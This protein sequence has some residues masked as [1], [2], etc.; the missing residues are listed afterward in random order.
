M[1]A[2]RKKLDLG[3]HNPNAPADKDKR[4]AMLEPDQLRTAIRFV[5]QGKQ[6]SVQ[7]LKHELDAWFVSQGVKPEGVKAD[8][9]TPTGS[10]QH[11]VRSLIDW[12]RRLTRRNRGAVPQ[13]RRLWSN[14]RARLS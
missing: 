2:A 13:L 8:R 10:D 7:L 14:C 12:V 5:K 6:S 11:D 9:R 3:P 1:M 4:N